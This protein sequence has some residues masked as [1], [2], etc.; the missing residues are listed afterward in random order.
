MREH[1]YYETGPNESSDVM[2]QNWAF[3]L[4]GI[5]IGLALFKLISA[6]R[7]SRKNGRGLS[8]QDE[9]V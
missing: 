7:H 4:A 2:Q 1:A 6:V 3:G 5:F 9:V 8:L